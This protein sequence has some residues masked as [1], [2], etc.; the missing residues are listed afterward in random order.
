VSRA[1]PAPDD[2]DCHHRSHYECVSCRKIVC[3]RCGA[4][5][6]A[7]TDDWKTT[8]YWCDDCLRRAQEPK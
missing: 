8:G 6:A 3:T 2:P 1:F 7:P 5:M 4:E